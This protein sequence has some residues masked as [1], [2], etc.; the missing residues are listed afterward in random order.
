MSASTDVTAFAQAGLLLSP[1]LRLVAVP[2]PLG[3]HAASLEP[4]GG[5]A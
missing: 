3:R 4:T 5:R 2:L 1:R